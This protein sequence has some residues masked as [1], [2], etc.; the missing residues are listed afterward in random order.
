MFFFRKKRQRVLFDAPVAGQRLGA[1]LERLIGTLPAPEADEVSRVAALCRVLP[2]V[3][4]K[5]TQVALHVFL[6]TKTLAV[7]LTAYGAALALLEGPKAFL[8]LKDHLTRSDFLLTVRRLSTI[9]LLSFDQALEEKDFFAL[10][11]AFLSLSPSSLW[12]AQA[13]FL[14]SASRVAPTEFTYARER[15]FLRTRVVTDPLFDQAIKKLTSVSLVSVVKRVKC[16]KTG[17][18]YEPMFEI[19]API[20][21]S[22]LTL[23]AGRNADLLHREKL[24]LQEDGALRAKVNLKIGAC[25]FRLPATL[26]A[27]QSGAF[28]EVLAKTLTLAGSSSREKAFYFVDTHRINRADSLPRTGPIALFV[29]LKTLADAFLSDDALL[30]ELAENFCIY[31]GSEATSEGVVVRYRMGSTT[32]GRVAPYEADPVSGILFINQ[33]REHTDRATRDIT[34][35]LMSEKRKLIKD[36]ILKADAP[37]GKIHEAKCALDAALTLREK[38]FP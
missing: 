11:K 36:G 22:I 33:A 3:S 34:R 13:T 27:S 29:P 28:A 5:S 37:K 1:L 15:L 7:F 31:S 35:R 6:E 19:F 17:V 32:E 12:R 21:S 25:A 10:L 9:K 23:F 24:Y 14:I 2:F 8:S 16:S 26:A 20:K 30:R 4:E 18:P 38:S